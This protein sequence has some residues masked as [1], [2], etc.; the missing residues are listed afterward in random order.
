MHLHD[1][2]NVVDVVDGFD[3]FDVVVPNDLSSCAKGIHFKKSPQTMAANKSFGWQLSTDSSRDLRYTLTHTHT[4]ARVDSSG[5][6][7]FTFCACNLLLLFLLSSV[8]LLFFW[9]EITA[10]TST[11]NPGTTELKHLKRATK[12]LSRYLSL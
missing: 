4:Y 9:D 12:D 8:L 10:S 11:P 5:P 6:T 7:A 2:V 1:V 3:V